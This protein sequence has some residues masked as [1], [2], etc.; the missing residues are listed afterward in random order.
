MNRMLSVRERAESR[1]APR[2]ELHWK[3]G[4]F[5]YQDRKGSGQNRL[6][7]DKNRILVFNLLNLECSWKS[8]KKC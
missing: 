4:F 2:F 6:G 5:I 7:R 1:M 8:K 3:N